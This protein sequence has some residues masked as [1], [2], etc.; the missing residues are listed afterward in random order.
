MNCKSLDNLEYTLK[1]SDWKQDGVGVAL[2]LQ[3]NDKSTVEMN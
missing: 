2:L 1:V 3:V